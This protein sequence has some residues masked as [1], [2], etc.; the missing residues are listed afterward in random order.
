VYGKKIPDAFLPTRPR[1]AL[2][3]VV[4]LLTPEQVEVVASVEL[5]ALF[6]GSN[7]Q[8]G[9][10]DGRDGNRCEHGYVCTCKCVERGSLVKT[11]IRM[12]Q[13]SVDPFDNK[14]VANLLI[15]Q[16]VERGCV[17]DAVFD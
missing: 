13:K 15:D 1:V 4:I 2:P 3:K 17:C 6:G 5:S 12:W 10:S 7:P 11:K 8:G 14:Y 9:E 16:W